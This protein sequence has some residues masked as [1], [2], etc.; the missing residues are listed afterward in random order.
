MGIVRRSDK[1]RFKSG[2]QPYKQ[3]QKFQRIYLKSSKRKLKNLSLAR[4]GGTASA[5]KKSKKENKPIK[6]SGTNQP[7]ALSSCVGKLFERLIKNRLE[8]TIEKDRYL[9][10]HQYGFRKGKGQ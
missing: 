6:G 8:M 5:L 1:R 2:R 9:S 10:D 7:I 4:P 3:L